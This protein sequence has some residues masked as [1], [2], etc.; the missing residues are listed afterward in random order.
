MAD[1]PYAHLI[2][3]VRARCAARGIAT[4]EN[5]RD[6][7]VVTVES[8]GM[9]DDYAPP[10]DDGGAGACPGHEWAYT[11]TAYGGDDESYHGEGRCY[12]IHCGA[13]GDA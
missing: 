5:I 4:P 8:M 10:D 11:G 9:E 3:H 13:D 6:I 7:V 1:D 12:C 2:A